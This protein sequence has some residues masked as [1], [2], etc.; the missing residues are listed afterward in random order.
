MNCILYRYKEPEDHGYSVVDNV[1]VT[2]G[3]TDKHIFRITTSDVRRPELGDKFSSR[4]GKFTMKAVCVFMCVLV[5]LL[6]KYE[7]SIECSDH[8]DTLLLFFL[9]LLYFI[10][11]AKRVL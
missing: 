9:F 4:H 11:Q 6:F 3:I 1:V 10:Q 5:L 7:S 2:S 8:F